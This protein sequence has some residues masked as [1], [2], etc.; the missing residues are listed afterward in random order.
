MKSVG[1]RKENPDIQTFAFTASQMKQ[2]WKGGKYTLNTHIQG[3]IILV[4]GKG[5]I[6]TDGAFLMTGSPEHAHLCLWLREI[7]LWSPVFFLPP[8]NLSDDSQEREEEKEG[9]REGR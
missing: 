7:L 2:L 6:L 5:N 8:L 4:S 9:G 3:T 1:A